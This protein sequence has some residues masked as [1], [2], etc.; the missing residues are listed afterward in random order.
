LSIGAGKFDGHITIEQTELMAFVNAREEKY[1]VIAERE[2]YPS[3]IH[4]GD[5]KPVPI[6]ILPDLEYILEPFRNTCF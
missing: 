6:I 4:P 3:I 5:S 1:T 2:A